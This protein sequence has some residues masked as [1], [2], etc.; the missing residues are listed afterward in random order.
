MTRVG[1]DGSIVLAKVNRRAFG[2]AGGTPT[3]ATSVSLSPPATSPSNASQR[4][5][6][7]GTSNETMDDESSDG[8]HHPREW[9]LRHH[10]DAASVSAAHAQQHQQ[11]NDNRVLQLWTGGDSHKVLQDQQQKKRHLELTGSPE[12]RHDNN[13]D[14]DDDDGMSERTGLARQCLMGSSATG[15]RPYGLALVLSAVEHFSAVAGRSM[16]LRRAAIVDMERNIFKA[17]LFFGPEDDAEDAFDIDCRPSD[18][19]CLSHAT[20]CPVYVSKGIW[21]SHAMGIDR[22]IDSSEGL[23]ARARVELNATLQLSGDPVRDILPGDPEPV[24]FLKRCLQVA[25]AEEDYVGAAKIRDHPF[26][27]IQIKMK[28]ALENED[29]LE[30]NRLVARLREMIRD[31]NEGGSHHNGNGIFD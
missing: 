4:H 9:M 22:A 31:S 18:A 3:N 2:N 17:R 15:G 12:R 26:M 10:V 6:N 27:Q 5:E 28:A 16:V 14:N 13:N 7:D 8:P 29:V 11:R 30:A 25:L 1:D 24:K 19:L 21:A 20:G 23:R